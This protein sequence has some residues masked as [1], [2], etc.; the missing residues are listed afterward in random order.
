VQH[1]ERH[2]LR[3]KRLKRSLEVPDCAVAFLQEGASILRGAPKNSFKLGYDVRLIAL[4][5]ELARHLLSSIAGSAGALE[6]TSCRNRHL[7]KMIGVVC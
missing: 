5:D 1:P 6:R 3:V 2:A 7:P 4:R